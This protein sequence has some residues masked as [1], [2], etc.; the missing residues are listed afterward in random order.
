MKLWL[1]I[2]TF[3]FGLLFLS[4]GFIGLFALESADFDGAAKAVGVGVGMIACP[5]IFG[6][7][8]KKN[9]N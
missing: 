5:F 3:I 8:R 7:I 4:A 9:E 2:V 1:A 6:V